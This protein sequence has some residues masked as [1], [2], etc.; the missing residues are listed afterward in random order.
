MLYSIIR[1]L[2]ERQQLESKW[3][4]N[5]LANSIKYGERYSQPWHPSGSL[6]GA[7]ISRGKPCTQTL[8]SPQ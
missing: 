3:L 7:W 6:T 8:I 2:K 1:V 5:L 4:K